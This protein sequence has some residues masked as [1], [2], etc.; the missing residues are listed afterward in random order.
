MNPGQPQLRRTQTVARPRRPF[1]NSTPRAIFSRAGEVRATCRAGRRKES[2]GPAPAP[3][4]LSSW[5]E[6][7]PSGWEEALAA[8]ASK[9]LQAMENFSG[10]LAIAGQEHRRG[11]KRSH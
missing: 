10:T 3:N 5:I 1:W 11:N 8:T 7:E 6:R 9:N 2:K 4:T